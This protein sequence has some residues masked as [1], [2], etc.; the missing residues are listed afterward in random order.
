MNGENQESQENRVDESNSYGTSG[1]PTAPQEGSGGQAL[2]NILGVVVALALAVFFALRLFTDIDPGSED[3]PADV[4]RAPVTK[5]TKPEPS[6]FENEQPEGEPSGDE[7]AGTFGDFSKVRIIPGFGKGVVVVGLYKNSKD[8]AIRTPTINVDFLD[9]NGDVVESGKGYAARLFLDPGE[10]TPVSVHF[11]K[12]LPEY[13]SY[14]A[15]YEPKKFYTRPPRPKLQIKNVKVKRSTGRGYIVTGE[16]AN[17]DKVPARFI[18][19]IATLQDKEGGLVG[20]ATRSI[21]I[22]QKKLKPGYKVKFEVK[23]YYTRGI[24]KTVRY[25]YFARVAK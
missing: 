15:H 25:D 1:S 17:K 4:P 24:P 12:G 14:K 19:I 23:V 13:S 2:I 22:K 7:S 8:E 16:I 21:R 18:R 11:N 3:E 10:V 20:T 6:L 9:K 5:K